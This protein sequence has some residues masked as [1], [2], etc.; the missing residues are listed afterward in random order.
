MTKIEYKTEEEKQAII[1]EKT[2]EGLYLTEEQN[3]IDG[4]FLIF[5]TEPLKPINIS[6]LE[7]R[8]IDL[9]KRIDKIEERI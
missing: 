9:E 6:P 2:T 4:N 5:D 7:E 3:H 8:I 1:T